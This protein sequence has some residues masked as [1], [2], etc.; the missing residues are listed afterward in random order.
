MV[1]NS[2]LL[3]E[4]ANLVA[5]ADMVLANSARNGE[6]VSSDYYELAAK[7]EHARNIFLVL[8]DRDY[9]LKRNMA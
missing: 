4:A 7:L 6:F 9:K 8:G 2:K 3:E 1:D 5:V